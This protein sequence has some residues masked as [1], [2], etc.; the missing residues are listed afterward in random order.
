MNKN[1]VKQEIITG[2]VIVCSQ[3]KYPE[4]RRCLQELAGEW[5]DNG[6][7]IYSMIALNEVKRLDIKFSFEF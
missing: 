5:V 7:A 4:V 2:N 3:D 6:Q 1:Q